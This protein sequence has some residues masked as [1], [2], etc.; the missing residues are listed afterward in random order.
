MK[1]NMLSAANSVPGQGVGSATTE[2]IDLINRYG[3]GTIDFSVNSIQGVD[4]LHAQTIGICNYLRFTFTKSAKIIH[5]HFLPKTLDGSLRMPS[6]IFQALKKYTI[7]FYKKADYLVVVNPAL[8]PDMI[9][10]GLDRKK[11]F[12]IPNFVSKKIF[13]EIDLQS[14]EQIRNEY[15]ITPDDFVVLG[16]GQLQYRKGVPDFIELAIRLPEV[17]FIWAGGFSFGKITD[18]YDEIR[19]LIKNA[20]SNLLFTGIIPRE[21]MNQLFGIADLYFSPAYAELFPMTILESAAC[22]TPLLLRKLDLYKPI[23]DGMYAVGQTNEDFE[24]QILR[25]KNDRTYYEKYCQSAKQIAQKYSEEHIWQQWLAFY[26]K[27]YNDKRS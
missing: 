25:L 5:V 1:I 3:Q 9:E 8:I 15:K 13:H 18:G 26:Q 7:R 6:P 27:V 14:K 12:C 11:I 23:L 24:E 19:T 17:K 22:G 2:L 21:K 4:I 16:A 10:S 20:P